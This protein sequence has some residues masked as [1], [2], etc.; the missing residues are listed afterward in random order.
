MGMFLAHGNV[1]WIVG[2]LVVFVGLIVFLA[3]IARGKFFDVLVAVGIWNFVYM[4]HSGSNAG[5]MTATFAALL[6]DMLGMPI[7]RLLRKGS[8]H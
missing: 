1:E 7:L 3:K 4:I 6:F 8:R 5:I 2:G